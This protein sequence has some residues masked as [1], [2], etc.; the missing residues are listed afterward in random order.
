[1]NKS[2]EFLLKAI[3]L[4]TTLFYGLLPRSVE[5]F[6]SK[7]DALIIIFT[8]LFSLLALTYLFIRGRTA[9][10]YGAKFKFIVIDSLV[11]LVGVVL[12]CCVDFTIEMK[13]LLAIFLIPLFINNYYVL[14]KNSKGE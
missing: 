5:Y 8:V 10:R 9:I 4:P 1:M 7:K 12:A 14:R 2:K 6:I 11:A 13:S 3:V